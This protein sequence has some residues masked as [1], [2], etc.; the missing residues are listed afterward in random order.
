MLQNI[1]RWGCFNRHVQIRAFCLTLKMLRGSYPWNCNL[2]LRGTTTMCIINAKIGLR[3]FESSKAVLTELLFSINVNTYVFPWRKLLSASWDVGVRRTHVLHNFVPERLRQ[4]YAL[5]QDKP[6]A[7]RGQVP[8]SGFHFLLQ[9]PWPP[10]C[11]NKT[12]QQ[13]DPHDQTK[14]SGN[15]KAS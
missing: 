5:L 14:P 8:H 4:L 9:L 1:D 12:S 15:P 3:S 2:Q 10:S 6:L 13:V 11:T 7:T